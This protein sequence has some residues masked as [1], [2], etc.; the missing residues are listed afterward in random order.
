MLVKLI[1]FFSLDSYV[2]YLLKFDNV[3]IKISYIYFFTDEI[4]LP[5]E[6]PEPVRPQRPTA[7]VIESR[8]AHEVNGPVTEGG[9]GTNPTG[10]PRFSEEVI[11]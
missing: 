4:Q 6:E 1:V 11:L 10:D 3:L 5:P 8:R 9:E 7:N 2:H